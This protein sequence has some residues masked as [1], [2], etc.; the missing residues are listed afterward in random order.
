MSGFAKKTTFAEIIQSPTSIT[1]FLDNSAKFT[2]E[3]NGGIS[4]WKLNGTI[5]NDLPP[6]IGRGLQTYL[7]ISDRGNPL[8]ILTFRATAIYNGSIIQC[9]TFGHFSRESE[10]ATLNIQGLKTFLCV[11]IQ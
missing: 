9:V 10:N 3:V 5:I 2:C 11:A 4:D 1:V 8:E 7:G 6:I